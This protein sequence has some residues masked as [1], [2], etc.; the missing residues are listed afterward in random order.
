MLGLDD[1]IDVA[2]DLV[3]PMA[4]QLLDDLEGGD[5]DAAAATADFLATCARA[6]A[7]GGV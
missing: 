3:L 6:V 7:D 1:R 5:L 2:Q 4:A